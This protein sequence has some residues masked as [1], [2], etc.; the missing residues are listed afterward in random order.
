MSNVATYG[1]QFENTYADLSK[2]F[3]A[4]VSPAR[5][6]SPQVAL[7][8][9]QLAAGLGLSIPADAD[10][11]VAALFAG[12]TIPVGAQPIAQAYAGHQYGGFTMLGD[13]RAILLGEHRTP[14][15]RL[16]DIQFKGSGPTPYSRNGDGLAALGPMLREY[17]VSEAMH[18]LSI[19]TTRSL[20]VVTTGENVQRDQRM[21][22]AVLTRVAASHI[23]V[24]TF[25]YAAT[26]VN[27]TA[28]RA[29]ADYAIS[30]HYPELALEP[31]PYLAFLRAV[32][33]RQ[34]ALVAS[35]QLVG[36]VHGVMNTDNMAVSGETIDYGPCA[37]LDEYHP[38]TVFSSIDEGGRYAYK[39]QPLI[40][41]WNLCRFAETLLPL[42]D[43]DMDNA[44]AAATDAIRQFTL[45]FDRYWL[46]G[47][48]RKLG[49][50]QE[51]PADSDLIQDLLAGMQRTRA[52]FTGTFRQLAETGQL[53]LDV[54]ND[55]TLRE[56]RSRW[57][58]RLS[59]EGQTPESA[60]SGMRA[61]NPAVIPRNHLVEQ[62]L[63]AA[64]DNDLTA[65]HDLLGALSNPFDASAASPKYRQPPPANRPRYR[66]FCGT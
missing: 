64:E 60:G 38:D 65:L 59:R 42:L 2:E 26:F 36:F 22:G 61:S 10:P 8:N 53:P 48:R 45:A 51:E 12:Q 58:E 52:D 15:G 30:R 5:F 32:I 57:T 37:F 35:W 62:A 16:V 47:M 27:A 3:F 13:G 55:G 46:G 50:Q 20:A 66:T 23:R 9:R 33:D 43:A 4:S 49:L 24:G 6:R 31:R 7:V 18:A 54:E 40:T 17:V 29:L 44:V 19:Q 11:S 28:V 25:Q 14:A 56:W 41:Q 63:K 39:N 21:P 34:A 1:W